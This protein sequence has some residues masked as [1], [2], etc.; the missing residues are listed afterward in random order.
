MSASLRAYVH[1]LFCLSIGACAHTY[2]YTHT[3]ARTFIVLKFNLDSADLVKVHVR[4]AVSAESADHLLGLL[5]NLC[6][7]NFS[8]ALFFFF[9]HILVIFE[10]KIMILTLSVALPVYKFAKDILFLLVYMYMI[11]I[12]M[13]EL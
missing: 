7:S 8:S 4:S 13:Y 2:I 6:L 1:V 3:R 9:F 12:I 5:F 11:V 10:L